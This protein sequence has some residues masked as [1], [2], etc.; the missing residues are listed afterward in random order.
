MDLILSEVLFI[1]KINIYGLDIL[2]DNYIFCVGVGFRWNC[3]L[4][5]SAIY[6]DGLVY[7]ENISAI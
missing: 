2:G 5:F 4:S 6:S 3:C 7:V 1:A